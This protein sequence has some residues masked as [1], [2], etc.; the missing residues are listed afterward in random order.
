MLE[1]NIAVKISN[2]T[3]PIVHHAHNRREVKVV[4]KEDHIDMT[5]PYEIILDYKDLESAYEEVFN[6]SIKNYNK[7]QARKDR[8]IKNYLQTILEDE[9]RCNKKESKKDNSRKPVYESIFKI[10]KTGN[11]INPEKAKK[12]LK[13]FVS[14]YLPSHYPNMKIIGVYM[15]DDEF[16]ID[17]ETKEKIPSPPHLHVDWIPVCHCLNE[18]EQKAEKERR[19]NLKEE[20]KRKVILAG[21]KWTK[22]DDAKWQK[23]DWKNDMIKLYGKSQLTGMDL[24]ASLTGALLEMGFKT[25]REKGWTAQMSFEENV[26]HSLE[27]F[28]EQREVL[29]DRTKSTTHRDHYTTNESL[30]SN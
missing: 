28:A 10:G 13:E 30:V 15:H 17:E 22:E 26:R 25:G 12:I 11:Q 2:Q 21:K 9:R 6:N 1:N 4:S 16:S 3:R 19:K 23:K 14:V 7:K 24:Q 27:N 8:K 18:E 5:R 29:I 20:A